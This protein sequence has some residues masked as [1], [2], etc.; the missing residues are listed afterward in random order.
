M[1]YWNRRYEY[2]QAIENKA[3]NDAQRHV[4]RFKGLRASEDQAT[5]E[6]VYRRKAKRYYRRWG[7]KKPGIIG[8]IVDKINRF[9][10]WLF[11]DK[12]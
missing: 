8:Y 12:K 9:F 11:E 7:T 1:A 10:D 5:V 2:N 4:R 3:W 6:R